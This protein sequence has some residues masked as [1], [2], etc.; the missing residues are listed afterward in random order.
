MSNVSASLRAMAF[1]SVKWSVSLPSVATFTAFVRDLNEKTQAASGKGGRP[2]SAYCWAARE[3]AE[4]QRA[5]GVGSQ[6]AMYLEHCARIFTKAGAHDLPLDT[7]MR[8][9][10]SHKAKPNAFIAILIV[11]ADAG[12]E[13]AAFP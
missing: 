6:S 7:P 13:I 8:V 2:Y 11:N 1:G 5:L 10:E 4:R 3:I 12:A 9:L